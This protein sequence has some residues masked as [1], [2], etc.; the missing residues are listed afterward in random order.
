MAWGSEY[1][2]RSRSRHRSYRRPRNTGPA[3]TGQMGL[4]AYKTYPTTTT[5]ASAPASPAPTWGAAVNAP[6]PAPSPLLP[7]S[8]YTA[9][10]GQNQNV[11]N[12]TAAGV[13]N[14]QNQLGLNY[15]VTYTPGTIAGAEKKLGVPHQDASFTIDPNID[16]SNP[17][18]RAGLLKRAFQN[19]VRGTTNNYAS[20]GQ[21]YSGALQNA[22][23]A[24]TFNYQQ[25]NDALIKGFQSQYGDTLSTLL[26]A[27]N[28]LSQSDI[29]ALAALLGRRTTT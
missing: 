26:T 21:L 10:L 11:Y 28:T 22:Q 6:P 25:G 7:D 12:Q 17:F 9:Q 13:T 14:A 3:L 15:G 24:N 4:D 2:R 29:D 18:S 19:N 8:A 1:M 5:K 23:N 27:G 20:Q 16:V